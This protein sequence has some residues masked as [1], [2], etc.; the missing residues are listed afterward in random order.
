MSSENKVTNATTNNNNS[1]LHLLSKKGEPICIDKNNNAI[2]NG[3][4]INKPH[5][6]KHNLHKDCD[7]KP[8]STTTNESSTKK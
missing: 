5:T 6:V 1:K 7:P 8:S 2:L 3:K 4:I